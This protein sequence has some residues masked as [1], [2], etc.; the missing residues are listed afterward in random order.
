MQHV[1]EYVLTIISERSNE[2]AAEACLQQ[3]V[4]RTIY[5]IYK[6]HGIICPGHV[7]EI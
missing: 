2:T 6:L 1:T 4:M 7:G 5:C 3:F